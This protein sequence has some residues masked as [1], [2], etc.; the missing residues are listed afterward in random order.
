MLECAGLWIRPW[1]ISSADSAGRA[2][3]GVFRRRTILEPASNKVVGFVSAPQRWFS[4]LFRQKMEVYEGEDASLLMTVW[5]PGWLYR[6]WEIF[7]AEDRP[8]GVVDRA[9]LFDGVGEGLALLDLAAGQNSGKFVSPTGNDLGTFQ[10]LGA[11]GARLTFAHNTDPFVRM[12]LL[13]A[14]LSFG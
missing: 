8:R 6:Y 5:G 13:G 7:D 4:W 10:L 14:V 12:V 2:H 11:E 1:E 9:W 3:R